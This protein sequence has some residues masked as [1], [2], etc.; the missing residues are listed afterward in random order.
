MGTNNTPEIMRGHIE[1]CV[2]NLNTKL[3]NLNKKN[4]KKQKFLVSLAN[5]CNVNKDTVRAWIHGTGSI[6]IAD[7]KIK[8][9][10]YLDLLGYRIIELENMS[11]SLRGFT[12]LIAFKIIT[13]DEAIALTGYIKVSSIYS[14]ING[15]ENSS[16]EKKEKIW[17]IWKDKKNELEK[18]KE[19]ALLLLP[20]SFSTENNTFDQNEPMS[21][22]IKG[23]DPLSD[24]TFNLMEGLLTLIESGA[25][26]NLTDKDIA[27]LTKEKII[28]VSKLSTEL[29]KFKDKMLR[30]KTNK[31]G[32]ENEQ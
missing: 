26:D 12:E 28:I 2:A 29:L 23:K 27:S 13:I 24:A 15:Q 25:L 30:K 21:N 8:L 17:N 22:K 11:V 3:A 19:K 20:V 9:M 4:D 16:P 5:F 18:A 7:K 14:I 6:P 1:E 31:K 32:G 10:C